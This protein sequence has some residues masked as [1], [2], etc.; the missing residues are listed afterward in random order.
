MKT[1]LRQ[2]SPPFYNRQAPALAPYV[3]IANL[4]TLTWES[5]GKVF[6]ALVEELTAGWV[7]SA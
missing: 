4:I 6:T 1:A 5:G 7:C 3:D 2:C